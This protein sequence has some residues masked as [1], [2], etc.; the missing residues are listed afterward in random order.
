MPHCTQFCKE[1]FTVFC[2]RSKKPANLFRCCCPAIT[3][4]FLLRHLLDW[5][6]SI[7]VWPDL[8]VSNKTTNKSAAH[9]A[10]P[11]WPDRTKWLELNG[12]SLPTENDSG[13][14]GE[15]WLGW[16]FPQKWSI[17]FFHF[18][19]EPEYKFDFFPPISNET[20]LL[21]PPPFFWWM[22]GYCFM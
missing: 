13:R 17:F 8:S 10:D 12:Y 4:A 18:F 6:F 22:G 11:I 3:H 9:W 5:G 2:V 16:Y 19:H 7:D 14:W 20:N 15:T 21:A 1:T